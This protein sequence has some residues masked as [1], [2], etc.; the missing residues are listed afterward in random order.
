MPNKLKTYTAEI[1]KK[2][3]SLQHKTDALDVLVWKNT[4]RKTIQA[5]IFNTKKKLVEILELV[6]HIEKHHL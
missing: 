2:A 5:T 3:I 6:E 4:D 1:N